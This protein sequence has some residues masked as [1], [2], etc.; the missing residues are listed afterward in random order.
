MRARIRYVLRTFPRAHSSRA[1]SAPSA[2]AA[3]TTQQPQAARTASHGVQHDD[4]TMHTHHMREAA[5]L[6][7]QFQSQR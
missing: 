7:F 5:A 4:E 1:A 6:L 3:S 2:A